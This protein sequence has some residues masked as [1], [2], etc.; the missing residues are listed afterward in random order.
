[1]SSFNNHPSIQMIKDKYQNFFNFKFEPASTAQVI[2]F[3][4]EIYCSKSS[5][6]DIPAKH[7]QDCKRR[8]GGTNNKLYK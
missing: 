5:S 8:I 2:K 3:N 4:D 7:Y 6:G 1:M